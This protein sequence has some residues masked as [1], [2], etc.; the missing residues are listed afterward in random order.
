[1]VAEGTQELG[2]KGVATVKRW[3]E[4]TTYIELPFDVYNNTLD[5]TIAH[6]GGVKRFDLQGYYLTGNKGP[7][8]V[9]SKRYDSAGGQYKEFLRFLAIAYSSTVE[10]RRVY[11]AHKERHFLWVTFHPFNLEHWS[12]FESHEHMI[13]ALSKNPDMLAEEESV[14]EDLVR[15]VASRI[16]VLVFNPKQEG[17]SLTRDELKAVRL[18]IDRKANSL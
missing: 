16:M 7:I 17:L 10:E 11:G 15:E 18:Q 12:A 4:A 5:C 13:L 8:F 9:E 6:F 14:D 2:R 3:L 1:M